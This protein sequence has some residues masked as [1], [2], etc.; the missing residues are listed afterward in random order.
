M[1][2]GYTRTRARLLRSTLVT[3]S[4]GALTETDLEAHDRKLE[5]PPS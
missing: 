4:D 1:G 3:R 5:A 2:M